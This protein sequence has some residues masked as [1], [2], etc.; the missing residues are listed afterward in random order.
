MWLAWCKRYLPNVKQRGRVHTHADVDPEAA[1]RYWTRI[2]RI[3][4]DRNVAVA[5]PR[6]DKTTTRISIR[7]TLH[8][9]AGV[10]STEWFIKTMHWIT[11]L[12]E[13]AF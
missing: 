3:E 7:G 4:I 8:I 12:N 13:K 10:G 11:K 5:K 9:R 1:R 2:A 6:K